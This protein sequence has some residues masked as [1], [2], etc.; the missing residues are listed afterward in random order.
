M[1]SSLKSILTKLAL[2][3]IIVCIGIAAPLLPST[4]AKKEAGE[5]SSKNSRHIKTASL[6][7]EKKED[8]AS[9]SKT[10]GNEFKSPDVF[11]VPLAGPKNPGSGRI[12]KPFAVTTT[13]A[14]QEVEPNGTS[15]TA[16]P[17]GGTDVKIKGDV[18]PNGD[19]DFYSF[20][21]A[22]GDRL[23]AG[24]MTAASS[25]GA[26]N[27]DS[28]LDVIA[29]D[30][31][32]V[33]E[34][35]N[36]DGSF[37]TASSSI[38]GTTLP[39]AGTY[40]LRVRHNLGTGQLRP[41]DLYVRVRTGAPTAETEP[42]DTFPGQ[43]LPASGWVSGSTSGTT[44]V[45]FYSINLNA[46]DTVFVS[47]DL[48]PERDTT[49]WNGQLGLGAFGTPPLVLVVND[50]G[51]ATPDSEA[52]YM[53]VKAAGTYGVF[54]GLPTGG[55]TFGTYHLNVSVLPHVT[56]G[57]N[58]TTYTSTNVP[59]AIPDGPSIVTSTLTVPGNPRIENI[60]V[61]INLTHNFMADLDVELTSP[62]GNTIGLF[63]DV[64]SVTA[65]SQTTM[66][67]NLDDYAAI[68]IGQ[69][70]VVQGIS[71][72]PE[73]NYRLDWFK[74]QPAGGTWT[75]TIRDDAAGDG[76]SLTGW[77]IEI[78]EP[79]AAP[80]CSMGLSS[81][82][83]F[84]TDFES[85]AAGFTHSGTADEWELGNPTAI[86]VTGC[87]SGTNCWKTDLDNTYNP[88][89]SQDLLS[90]NINLAGIS[91]PI[92]LSWAQKFQIETATFD[93]ASVDV[94]IVGN[95]A[96]AVR[97]WEWTG[98]TMTNAVGN[99]S[100][101]VQEAGGWGI[102]NADISSFAGQNIEVLF[103]LDSDTTV[104][105][106][107]LAIDDV[108]VTGCMV[109]CTLTCP[110]NV[111]QS[112]DPNQC[113]AVVTYPAPTTTGS[114][115]TVTCSPPSGSFFPVGT[116]TVTCTPSVGSSCSFTV[117]VNDTQ[118]PTITCPANANVVTSVCGGM[119]TVVNY[120]PPTASDNCPGVT[121]AC[122]P[123][124]GSTLP[125]GVT[126]VTCTATDAAG[127]TATCSFTVTVFNACLQ[128]DNNPNI[129]L[130][131]NTVTG[132]YSFCC[133]G[134]TYT[135]TGV[136]T[137]K[138]TSHSINHMGTDRRINGVFDCATSKG[139]GALQSNVGSLICAINDRDIRNNT[140]SC[141][142]APPP[143]SSSK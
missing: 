95:P 79:P 129:V 47:L 69:F 23:Y 93:H 55:T 48:D 82:T 14:G 102:Y 52:F 39:T 123:P 43:A 58:C 132:A 110:A 118:P 63:S 18:F 71:F 13:D 56:R 92:R 53:T 11:E 70:T 113:G 73:L 112:N 44:D 26:P 90:P 46:G 41:Y 106:G 91:G 140:C 61:N 75:L 65:G 103:H 119:S 2:L 133:N 94:R 9:T 19:I 96:S 128:D 98:A 125:I 88:S 74:G 35:D 12:A 104:Q 127:N 10:G 30:G 99:P 22:A 32:T 24:V 68:P 6:Q 57:I 116:T 4:S 21:A 33:I 111:T 122:V 25:S 40:F 7:D 20:T 37:G 38:A 51:A 138:G 72:Q 54:V 135:G 60:R 114:C 78:C 126:T 67:I 100:V 15:A 101:T 84:T 97:V 49:E 134:T 1:K 80:A 66:D 108:S 29:S 34:T 105:L 115:G 27:T 45:D 139:Q 28:V 17:L 117:T 64:G 89:S 5:S 76:G 107:G 109:S 77:S 121:A 8:S 83:V 142:G 42:N 3:S 131:W 16:T 31:T 87:N 124:S 143:T 81:T 86:P 136:V 130:L 36:D 50:A 137:N 141:G 120:P 62:T 59:V 85:G